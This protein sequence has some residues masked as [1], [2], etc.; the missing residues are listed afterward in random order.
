MTNAECRSE[1]RQP[2]PDPV[3]AFAAHRSA[4]PPSPARR[5][6]SRLEPE[7]SAEAKVSWCLR[8]VFVLALTGVIG[9]QAYS[10]IPG[11]DLPAARK[12]VAVAERGWEPAVPM[13]AWR[14]IVVHHS[15]TAGGSAALFEKYHRENRHWENG[16]GY[17]F[18]IG[19][20]VDVPDGLVEIGHR[21]DQQLQGAH[22]GGELNKE[23]IGVCLVGDFSSGRATA[24]QMAALDRLVR[25]LQARCAIPTTRVL[26]HSE[27]RPG[28][29]VCPGQ[30]F[31]MSRLRLSLSA[32]PAYQPPVETG[33]VANPPAA[34]APGSAPAPAG[35][36]VPAPQS[37]R[38]HGSVRSL[39]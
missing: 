39:R 17:H 2:F 8:I 7:T 35:S 4:L 26:G 15:A 25:F 1:A 12:P 9:C 13:H 37:F 24:K 21:W 10:Q 34:P 29:T 31:S 5:S 18:V 3:S 14:Y 16:M 38:I 32:S 11:A 23:C 30:N 27:V 19:N 28:Q 36:A 20:G 33:P 22:V 6:S